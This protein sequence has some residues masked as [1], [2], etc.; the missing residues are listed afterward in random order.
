MTQ[1]AAHGNDLALVVERMGQNM[2]EDERR[3]ADGVVSIGEMKFRIG[4]EL[5]IR[6]AGQIY[7][8]LP[9]DLLL[10]E[11]G[12]SNIGAFGAVAVDVLEPLQRVNPKSFAVEDVNHLFLQRGEPEAGQFFLIIARGDCGQV[13]EQEI[14]AGV[15]PAVEFLNAI[16]GE[17]EFL[18]ASHDNDISSEKSPIPTAVKQCW[19]ALISYL[20]VTRPQFAISSDPVSKGA[21]A[22]IHPSSL[23]C[24]GPRPSLRAFVFFSQAKQITAWSRTKIL[25]TWNERPI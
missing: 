7:P 10:Q 25:I 17:Q 18:L 5:L 13:V 22:M 3:S 8:G 2:M 12:S 11:S 9:A 14:E 15:G 4:I 21:L 20:P 6:Q 23:N 19:Q 24:Q 1:L 16:E